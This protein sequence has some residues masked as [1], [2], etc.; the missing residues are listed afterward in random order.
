MTTPDDGNTTEPVG[1]DPSDPFT[2]LTER[3]A[4]RREYRADSL[5]ELTR[6]TVS[7]AEWEQLIRKLVEVA[8]KGDVR[9]LDLLC[10]YRFGA[11][12]ESGG[13]QEESRLLVLRLPDIE[14]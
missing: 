10:K 1:Q 11:A 4:S 5:A 13:G 3:W 2:E 12:R 8:L 14:E 6:R 7:P 9:A